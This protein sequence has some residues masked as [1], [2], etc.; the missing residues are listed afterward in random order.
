MFDH[1]AAQ[2]LPSVGAASAW[3]AARHTNSIRPL[4]SPQLAR[5]TGH[6]LA[7]LLPCLVRLVRRHSPA[8]TISIDD[9]SE[10][11]PFSRGHNSTS[12]FSGAATS[13]ADTDDSGARSAAADVRETATGLVSVV[14]P[15]ATL[16]A[17]SARPPTQES[18]TNVT[19]EPFV[20]PV[21]KRPRL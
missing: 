12:S 19:A 9:F 17:C 21:A 7:D 16:P 5:R 1:G 14:G 10:P 13:A 6:A 4:W 3:A 2:H 8:S 11:G 20:A 18:P 15:P